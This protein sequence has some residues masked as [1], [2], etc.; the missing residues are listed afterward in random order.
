MFSMVKLSVDKG[1]DA[2]ETYRFD[3]RREFVVG[4]AGDCDIQ[5]PD[6]NDYKDISLHHCVFHIEPPKIWLSVLESRNGTFVNE[7]KISPTVGQFRLYDEDEVQL[8]R[9][10]MSVHIVEHDAAE[11]FELAGAFDNGFETRE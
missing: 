1:N 3:G 11:S 4:R 7:M 6:T 8:G 10:R 9:L 2:G 5:V